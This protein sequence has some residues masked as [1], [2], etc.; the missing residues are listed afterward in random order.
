MNSSYIVLDINGPDNFEI[1][2]G[3]NRT[4]S[5][6]VTNLGNEKI[7][8]LKFFIQKL[9]LEWQKITPESVSEL[10]PNQTAIF[11]VKINIPLDADIK[12]YEIR[13]TAASKEVLERKLVT[14]QVIGM[15]TIIVGDIL[16]YFRGIYI[17]ILLPAG[18]IGAL[19]TGMILRNRAKEKSQVIS[20][21]R[22]K[23]EALRKLKE[24]L[25]SK[26]K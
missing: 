11:V 14:M 18:I 23:S 20:Y 5:V 1:S 24:K 7:Y 19:I 26:Q 22:N 3:D 12:P 25:Q 13:L 9:P 2:Q 17:Y 8:N 6:G 10:E 15:P 16:V 4:F 21:E